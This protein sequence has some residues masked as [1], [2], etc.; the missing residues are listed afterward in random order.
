MTE[1]IAPPAPN[2]SAPA[3]RRDAL[4][5]RVLASLGG[6]FDILTIHLGDRLGFYRVLADDGPVS[7]TE[8]AART[9][10]QERYV[11]EWLE[12]QATAGILTV[13]D[14]RR[15][16]AQRRF[17]LPAGHDEV[18]A[19]AESLDYLA[20]IAQV[21][22]GAVKPLDR[23]L[24]VFRDGGGIPFEAYGEDMREGQ[25]R[26]NRASFLKLIGTE[27]IP[28]LP[29]VHRRLTAGPARVADLGCGGGW[30]CIG[31]AS[32]YPAARVDGFDL[33]AP[34]VELARAHV[35]RYGLEDRVTVECRD[36][37]DPTLEG[38]YDL[39][40]AFECV[41][42]LSDPVATL[43]TMRR[44]VREDGAVL[45]VDERV[46]ERFGEPGDV[47]GIMYGWSVLHCLPVGMAEQPAAGTGTVMRPDTLRAYAAEA[48]F[49]DL[50]VLDV[51]NLFFRFYRLLP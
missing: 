41:H 21:F 16:A 50:E 46:A 12:Q 24:Q 30:S 22:V 48:G 33:D 25:A 15:P 47:D 32:A 40:T 23:L 7:S 35:R 39:V 34:S 42:D 45:V 28:A 31:I 9:G 38:R 10:T 19:D 11:R 6:A 18:L 17:D 5:E 2:P 51:E 20:P 43:R 44:L 29:D 14:P 36:A 3:A 37:G 1:P 26:V 8:L 27:W 4:A 13:D 49:R